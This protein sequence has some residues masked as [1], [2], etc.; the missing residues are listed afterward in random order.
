VYDGAPRRRVHLQ[1]GHRPLLH[2]GA[3]GPAQ[4]LPR[5]G[6]EQR[7]GHGGAVRQRQE[8]QAEADQ[9]VAGADA[10][11]EHVG[12][13]ER[14]PAAQERG[15]DDERH[16]EHPPLAL[17]PIPVAPHRPPQGDDGGHGGLDAQGGGGRGGGGGQRRGGGGRGSGGGGGDE[18]RAA[19]LFGAVGG[20]PLPRPRLLPAAAVRREPRL[21]SRQF[22]VGPLR[23]LLYVG[24]DADVQSPQ[25]LGV[26]EEHDRH[27]GEEDGHLQ[28]EMVG[29]GQTRVRAP[30]ADAQQ[31]P[32]TPRRRGR[33]LASL[34]FDGPPHLQERD[35][36]HGH[37][38]DP[39]GGQEQRG[40]TRG[41][42]PVGGP[43]RDVVPVQADDQDVDGRGDAGEGD[44]GLVEAAQQRHVGSRRQQHD[45]QRE[46]QAQRAHRHVQHVQVH[47]HHVAHRVHQVGLRAV[48][49]QHRQVAA[50][51]QHQLQ[52]EEGGERHLEAQRV[53]RVP[54]E[55][56]APLLPEEFRPVRAGRRPGPV[57]GGGG[58]ARGVAVGLHDDLSALIYCVGHSM[59]HR[60]E[61]PWCGAGE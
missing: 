19:E 48:E 29:H 61:P 21:L 22:L 45:R 13:G 14:R 16:P 7:V 24:A 47:R 56:A 23:A 39:H 1:Q 17:P 18:G 26:G 42:Q 44:A 5:E 15:D 6:V 38:G 8:P 46:R 10:Q 28:D 52:Q 34:L 20:A 3:Q 11:D 55:A 58:G 35:E 49:H 9:R 36:K 54:G 31:R 12:D 40:P 30:P 2:L 51:A 53:R 57:G 60:T 41:Q 50:E 32:V 25:Y 59:M 27:R 33:R 4:L 43:H 37:R